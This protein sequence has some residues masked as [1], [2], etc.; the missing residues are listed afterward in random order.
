MRFL[1]RHEEGVVLEPVVFAH[2]ECAIRRVRGEAVERGAEPLLAIRNHP[3]EGDGV[4]GK[5]SLL[6]ASPGT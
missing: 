3:L 6:L 2:D 5:S 1:E 4:R